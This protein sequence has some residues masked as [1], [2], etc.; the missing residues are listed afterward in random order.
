MKHM[1][2]EQKKL[3]LWDKKHFVEN[4]TEIVQ[5]VLKMQQVSFLP[6]S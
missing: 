5:H 6:K 2:F 1:L 3:K 4:K